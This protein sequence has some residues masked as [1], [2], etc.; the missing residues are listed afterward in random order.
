MASKEIDID[1]DGHFATVLVGLVDNERREL[2]MANAGHPPALLLNG[3]RS[4]FIEVPVGLPLGIAAPAYD[5]V[6]IP[7][8]PHSTLIAYTDGLVERR[9]ES[10]DIGLERLRQSASRD[11][12]S[13]DYLLTRIVDDF[14]ADHVSDDDTAILAIRWHR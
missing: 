10:I 2:T 6:T 7:L 1:S 11:S 4:E 14:F 12:P 8:A 5:S 9:N 13:V 3:E